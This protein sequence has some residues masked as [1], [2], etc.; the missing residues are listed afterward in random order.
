MENHRGPKSSRDNSRSN[1]ASPTPRPRHSSPTDS[2]LTGALSRLSLPSGQSTPVSTPRPSSLLSAAYPATPAEPTKPPASPSSSSQESESTSVAIHTPP[3]HTPLR[4]RVPSQPVHYPGLNGFESSPEPSRS[5]SPTPPSLHHQTSSPETT[6][7]A[8]LPAQSKTLVIVHDASHKHK[9]SRNV[10]ARELATIVERPERCRASILGI[11][12][13]KS[14]LEIEGLTDYAFDV[15]K[16]TRLGNLT[17]AVVTDVHG[18]IWPNELSSLCDDAFSKVSNGELEIPAPYHSGD[19]YLGPDS[20]E[21]LRGCV[22]SVYDAVDNVLAGPYDRVHVSIRPPGHH[23][24]ETM[25]SGFC[26]INNIH[27]AIA[28]AHRMYGITRAA[29][30][31]FDLHHGDGSQAIAWAINDKTNQLERVSRSPRHA[32]ISPALRVGYFSVHDIYSFPC[33]E[34]LIEKV[35]DASLCLNAHGQAIW[36]VHLRHH[37]TPSSFDAV[38]GEEYSVLFK[39]AGEFLSCAEANDNCMV[40]LS[41]GFDGSEHESKGMQRHGYNLPTHF[42]QRFASDSIQ[43]ANRY[44]SGK[45][46]SVLEGGYADRAIT[47]GSYAFMIGL[48]GVTEQSVN[49]RSLEWW[50]L[51]RLTLLEKWAKKMHIA[52][53]THSDPDIRWAAQL[54]CIAA[55]YLPTPVSLPAESSA[56]DA[57]LLTTPRVG[58]R[59]RKKPVVPATAPPTVTKSRR[60]RVATPRARKSMTTTEVSAQADNAPPVPETLREDSPGA[61]LTSLLQNMSIRNDD[62]ENCEAKTREWTGSLPGTPTP[63]RKA[64]VND[65][66]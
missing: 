12:A 56:L 33:E 22:G 21:A 65:T 34:G 27:I 14:R 45:I 4:E 35:Q 31:D 26:M 16:S 3:V 57:S 23:C 40:F 63:S 36:N 37:T 11:A 7:E 13:A 28:Y 48:S 43:L 53:V 50:S 64:G 8:D 46:L 47:S 38:Y 32:S 25:P 55:S 60:Q 66:G 59:E 49:H 61:G 58:L 52:K 29:I 9:F 51:P 20:S 41:A 17:D 42:Y 54:C 44:A 2:E 1:T 39:R 62:Q 5:E 6:P 10:K 18:T 19:L 30:L 24:G 15:I